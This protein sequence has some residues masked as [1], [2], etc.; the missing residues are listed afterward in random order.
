M[1]DRQHTAVSQLARRQ[2]QAYDDA[3]Q[4]AATLVAQ[5]Q[6]AGRACHLQ[7]D[8]PARPHFVPGRK[9]QRTFRIVLHFGRRR[10]RR[11][12]AEIEM[13]RHHYTIL[14]YSPSGHSLVRRFFRMDADLTCKDLLT[15]VDDVLQ[16]ED[17]AA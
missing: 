2:A 15:E 1:F 11:L 6:R 10:V 4:R 13:G 7:T 3:R 14:V 12:A 17:V 5:L 8:F 9:P 16:E